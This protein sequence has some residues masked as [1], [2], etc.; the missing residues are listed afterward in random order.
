[1]RVPVSSFGD[2]RDTAP[3]GSYKLLPK[4]EAGALQNRF[5][6][7]YLLYGSG[8]TWR[9]PTDMQINHLY[10]VHWADRSEA[11]SLPLTHSV[12][13]IEALGRHAVIVGT[14]GR[15]LMF[16]SLRL[17]RQA[18]PANR[19]VRANAAQGETRSHGFFYKP[20]NDDSGMVGL[21]IVG[22]GRAGSRQLREDSAA[23]LYLRNDDLQ[24]NELGALESRGGSRNDGCR[25]SCVDWYG[26]ARPLF[27]KNR[28]FALMGY[29]LV[30]GRVEQG[31]I[32]E[33]RRVNFA[34]DA[35]GQ[36]RWPG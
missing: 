33:I 35:R 20:E 23:V 24:L 17:E 6:G 27:L 22:A 21:P 31:S 30:E 15:D 29:E 14:S 13:R 19:Y 12:D 1:M 10:A 7:Q 11:Q 3:A 18:I 28:V 9:R 32:D 8:N 4:P 34:P 5:V 2:G 36:A 26:N 16:S 25:A